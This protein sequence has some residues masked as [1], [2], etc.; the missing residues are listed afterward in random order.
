MRPRLIWLAFW[1]LCAFWFI[2]FYFHLTGGLTTYGLF[3]TTI[4]LFVKASRSNK[5]V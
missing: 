5:R 4:A 1:V 3:L 2:G